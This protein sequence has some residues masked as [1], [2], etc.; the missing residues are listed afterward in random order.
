[1]ETPIEEDASVM[2]Q[3]NATHEQAAETPTTDEPAET[4]N[5]TS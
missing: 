5:S 1:L 4:W 3:V 2:Q